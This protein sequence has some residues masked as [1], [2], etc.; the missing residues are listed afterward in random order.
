MAKRIKITRSKNS[1]SYSIIDDFTNPQTKKRPPSPWRTLETSA[2]SWNIS[3]PIPRRRPFVGSGSMS[4]SSVPGIRRKGPN[5]PWPCLRE[6]SSKRTRNVP[7][8]SVISIQGTFCFPWGSGT[9]VTRSPSDTGSNTICRRS[10][11]I[12]SVPVSSIRV[13]SVRPIRMPI[14]FWRSLN[15]LS[16]IFIVPC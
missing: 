13:P 4:N 16:M 6:N 7:I 8:I 9:S 10:W 12:L 1:S 15:I 2:S 3:V 11:Q 14:I 5:I